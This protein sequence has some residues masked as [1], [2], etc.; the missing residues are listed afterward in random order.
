M[1]KCIS[2]N[3]VIYLP[4]Y[5]HWKAEVEIGRKEKINKIENVQDD[6]LLWR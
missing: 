1:H 2:Q 6:F 3:M 5:E 4:S